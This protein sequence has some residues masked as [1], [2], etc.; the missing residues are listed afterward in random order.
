M[1]LPPN[2]APPAPSVSSEV[3]TSLRVLSVLPRRTL[4]S[5]TPSG[6]V[7]VS[8]MSPAGEYFQSMV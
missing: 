8:T 6:A 5:V 2:W 4:N 3:A 1:V 7:F